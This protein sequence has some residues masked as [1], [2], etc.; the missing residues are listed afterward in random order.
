[1]DSTAVSNETFK[2][3]K[4]GKVCSIEHRPALVGCITALTRD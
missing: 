1:V 3:N 2:S 4:A